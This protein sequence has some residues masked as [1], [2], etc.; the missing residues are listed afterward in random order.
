MDSS[1]TSATKWTITKAIANP[2]RGIMANSTGRASDGQCKC[3]WFYVDGVDV[4]FQINSICAQDEGFVTVQLNGKT[5]ELKV[6]TGGKCNVLPRMTFM[7]VSTRKDI[8]LQKT[9]ANLVTYGGSKIN[10][11]N[12][13]INKKCLHSKIY[14]RLKKC[15]WHFFWKGRFF[16]VEV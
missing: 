12:H 7:Q 3:Q 11:S 1:A 9:N 15:I 10:Q 16:L 2:S 8:T 4:T 6:D 14:V 13:S 5:V